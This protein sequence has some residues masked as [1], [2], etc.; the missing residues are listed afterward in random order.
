MFTLDLT[1]CDGS[2][3][4]I[5]LN[6]ICSIPISE[7]RGTLYGLPW[8]ASIHAKLIAY[9]I[10]GDSVMSDVGNGAIIITNPDAPVNLAE[11]YASRTATS[12]G[13]SWE[14]GPAN[15]GSQV[16][17]FTVSIA[18]GEN[19]NYVELQSYVI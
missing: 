1:Y 6:E 3:V 18:D 15:G 16:L 17:D 19:D 4:M 10:Y 13:L 7:L 11:V 5:V 12:L 14:L 9:N 8:G 2:Q